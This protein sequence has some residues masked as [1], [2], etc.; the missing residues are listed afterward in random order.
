MAQW[1]QDV[2]EMIEKCADAE[3][4]QVSSMISNFVDSDNILKVLPVACIKKNADCG[5]SLLELINA[6]VVDENET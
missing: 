2:L 3:K 6:F 5:E 1:A 4:P